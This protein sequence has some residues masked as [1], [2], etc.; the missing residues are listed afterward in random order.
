[1]TN[2]YLRYD[3]TEM[4]F[5]CVVFHE[6]IENEV[7]SGNTFS[8]T[9][10][11]HIT[12]KWKNYTI[13]ILATEFLYTAAVTFIR[14]FYSSNTK[15]FKVTGGTY[16]PVVLSESGSLPIEYIN[17]IDKLKSITLTMIDKNPTAGAFV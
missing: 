3:N 6:N 10:Y 4:D 15:Q 11:E 12:G 1:M 16:V 14:N 5:D 13:T 9:K 17:D 8:A 7:V 2:I